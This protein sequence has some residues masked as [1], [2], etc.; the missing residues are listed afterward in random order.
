MKTSTQFKKLK[1]Q[2]IKLIGED[3]EASWELRAEVL[4]TL[5]ANSELIELFSLMVS[6]GIIDVA[7][8]DLNDETDGYIALEAIDFFET[9]TGL[10]FQAGE[11]HTSGAGVHN[12]IPKAIT[13]WFDDYS[14]VRNAA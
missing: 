7:V 8:G 3:S 4:E 13:E 2:L 1:P 12:K 10:T 9:D 14:I 5:R 11:I 6:A